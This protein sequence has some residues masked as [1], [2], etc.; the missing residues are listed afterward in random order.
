[1][2]AFYECVITVAIILRPTSMYVTH[3]GGKSEYKDYCY[4][5][6]RRELNF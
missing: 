4:Y 1:M 2:P 3:E 5:H 6:W